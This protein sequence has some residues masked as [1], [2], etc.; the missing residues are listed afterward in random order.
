MKEKE[1]E[2]SSLTDYHRERNKKAVLA[3]EEMKKRTYTL[4]E[5]KEQTR[6]I[7]STVTPEDRGIVL[8]PVWPV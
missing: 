2:K 3:V 6:Q 5:M 1:E 7:L 4:E 8:E